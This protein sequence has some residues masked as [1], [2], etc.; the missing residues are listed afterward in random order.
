MGVGVPIGK[1]VRPMNHEENFVE[2]MPEDYFA[3]EEMLYPST[4]KCRKRG[5]K[6]RDKFNVRGRG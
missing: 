2:E 4:S 3:L 6:K 5:A 1:G